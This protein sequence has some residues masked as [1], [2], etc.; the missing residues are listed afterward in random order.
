MDKRRVVVTGLGT[1]NPIAKT[2]EGYYNALLSGKSGAKSLV[3][4]P[5]FTDYNFESLYNEFNKLMQENDLK[6]T[7]NNNLLTLD[8]EQELRYYIALI[9]TAFFMSFNAVYILIWLWAFPFFFFL[10][11]LTRFTD[12][13]LY[14]G[15]ILV[16]LPII[17][18]LASFNVL[19]SNGEISFIDAFKA[20]IS[21]IPRNF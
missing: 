2:K 13:S 21:K 16:S 1:V 19:D 9:L 11:A 7:I 20:V 17:I 18:L 5:E 12:P 14:Q 15:I 10:Y 4:R 3:G 6:S 8:F